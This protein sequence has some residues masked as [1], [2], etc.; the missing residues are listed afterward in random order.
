LQQYYRAAV[1]CCD[2]HQSRKVSAVGLDR[3]SARAQRTF[4]S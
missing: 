3:A 1:T 4:H 2:K